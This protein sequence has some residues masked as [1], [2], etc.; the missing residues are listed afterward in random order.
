MAIVHL[1]FPLLFN[2]LVFASHLAICMHTQPSRRVYTLCM[3][4]YALQ[5]TA[6][7]QEEPAC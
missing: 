4:R 5:E 6:L 7:H 2:R 1:G 3:R